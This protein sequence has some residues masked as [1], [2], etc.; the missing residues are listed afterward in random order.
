MAYNKIGGYQAGLNAYDIPSI[1]DKQQV[2]IP[3][4]NINTSVDPQVLDQKEQ[5]QEKELSLDV[6]PLPQRENASIENIAIS[7]GQY[8]QSSID[9][10]GER[11]LASGDMQKAISGMQ[12]DH[13]LHEYQYFVGGKDLTG[14]ENNRIIA[15]TEDGVA[16]RL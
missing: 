15:G 5:E 8:D 13:I 6:T 11:G 2:N 9:R 7:F 14:K 16:I 1:R 3:D 4:P 10:Y 12:K